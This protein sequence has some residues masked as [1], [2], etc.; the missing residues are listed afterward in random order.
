MRNFD[1][2]E[3]EEKRKKITKSIVHEGTSCGYHICY[4]KLHLKTKKE[5]KMHL[6]INSQRNHIQSMLKINVYFLCF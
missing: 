5:W 3:S 2:E 1:F 6:F 4:D